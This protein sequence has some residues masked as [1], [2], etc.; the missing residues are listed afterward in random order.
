MEQHCQAVAGVGYCSQSGPNHNRYPYRPCPCLQQTWVPH[1]IMQ[2]CCAGFHVSRL[3]QLLISYVRQQFDTVLEDKMLN[4]LKVKA[5]TCKAQTMP[6]ATTCYS[7]SGHAASKLPQ[8]DTWFCAIK[9]NRMAHRCC[10]R[11]HA[12][13]DVFL[14]GVCCRWSGSGH[15]M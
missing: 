13:K 15:S 3:L 10:S 8:Q 12:S 1:M 4:Q 2:H 14:T 11:A 5:A 7:G 6:Y 9:S